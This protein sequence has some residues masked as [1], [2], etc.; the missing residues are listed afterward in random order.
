[1][2][3]NKLKLK[4]IILEEINN[5]EE[6]MSTSASADDAPMSKSDLVK[7]QRATRGAD[8]ARS[9]SGLSGQEVNV[10][11]LLNKIGKALQAPGNQASANVIRLLQ[12]AL[13]QAS[14][15]AQE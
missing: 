6:I 4:E 3:I 11:A 2:K 8:L 1:M 14:K 9:A 13:Q 12:Q 5:M 7:Q 15:G 10:Q